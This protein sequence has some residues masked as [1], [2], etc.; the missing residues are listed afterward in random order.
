MGAR[1][2]WLDAKL[3]LRMLIRYP[4]RSS[5]VSPWRSPHRPIDETEAAF[6]APPIN[7]ED[8]E[9]DRSSVT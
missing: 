5:A 9:S 7:R 2:S 4:R 3:G 1:M 6:D 8:A